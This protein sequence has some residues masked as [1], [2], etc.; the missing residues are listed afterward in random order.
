VCV[1]IA[2]LDG[3]FLQ[4]LARNKKLSILQGHLL[5]VLTCF[6][7]FSSSNRGRGQGNI[8]RAAFR[9][10]EDGRQKQ[11]EVLDVIGNPRV[12]GG[13]GPFLDFACHY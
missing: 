1:T 7:C 8:L 9:D 13:S 11:R 4:H 6:C 5:K 2:Q 3:A 12:K 10:Q